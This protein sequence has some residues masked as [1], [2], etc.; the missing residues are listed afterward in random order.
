[1][2]DLLKKTGYHSI[3]LPCFYPPLLKAPEFR[4]I[5]MQLLKTFTFF[6]ALLKFSIFVNASKEELI[7]KYKIAAIQC[8]K[9]NPIS[10][11][12]Y[13]QST[14]D[15]DCKPFLDQGDCRV[16]KWLAMVENKNLGLAMPACQDRPCRGTWYLVPFGSL[17]GDCVQI[18]TKAMCENG[19]V[20]RPNI[21][22]FGN[23]LS[24]L[25]KIYNCRSR[26]RSAMLSFP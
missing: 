16:N 17:Q 21:F 20:V 15:F 5:K 4:P 23:F 18:G 19:E 12:V 26:F 9:E 22:G 2:F 25:L 3:S 24:N 13:N 11:A 1:M 6:I 14:K 8:L 7:K 10:G